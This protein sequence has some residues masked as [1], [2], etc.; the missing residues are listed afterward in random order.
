MLDYEK[1]LFDKYNGED[2]YTI[3]LDAE[4]D[5]RKFWDEITEEDLHELI[6]RMTK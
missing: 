6:I 1:R 5:N 3:A 2:G 4:E